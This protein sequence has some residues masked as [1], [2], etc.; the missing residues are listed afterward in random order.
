MYDAQHIIGLDIETDNSAGFGLQ[1]RK[2]RVTDVALAT[3]AGGFVF[4]QTDEQELLE[5][6]FGI[7]ASMPASLIVTWN[8]SFFDLPFL[9]DRADELDLTTGMR[10]LPQTGIKPKYDYLPGHSAGY[11]ALIPA[12]DGAVHTHVDISLAWK[13]FAD[14]AGV[15]W[16][17]KPVLRAAGYNPVELDRTRLQDYTPQEV[18]AYVRSDADG[19]RQLAL[20]TLGLD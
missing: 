19:A 8:G 3:E 10:L 4:Q 15:G 18:L 6:T 9:A 17:L 7:L 1:P 13:A 2:S 12:A 11:T 16:G 20:R 14:Q 5:A